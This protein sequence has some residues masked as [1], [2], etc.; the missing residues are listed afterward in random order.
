MGFW[1][2]PEKI[3]ISQSV[4]VGTNGSQE[5]L[6]ALLLAAYAAGNWAESKRARG[7]LTPLRSPEAPVQ[8]WS[9]PVATRAEVQARLSEASGRS[10]WLR[11]ARSRSGP[12]FLVG[13]RAKPVS[14][15]TLEVLVQVCGYME[16]SEANAPAANMSRLASARP[17]ERLT[18]APVAGSR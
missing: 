18:L 14:C 10:L 7:W 2:F 11:L 1:I 13:T 9:Y 4:R 5:Y 15:P 8:D 16:A 3:G 12:R 17:S 6:A